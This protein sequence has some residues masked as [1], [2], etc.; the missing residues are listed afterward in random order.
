VVLSV[1]ERNALL[2][3]AWELRTA[4]DYRGLDELLTPIPL[5]TL[6]SEPEL[7]YWLASAW[8][9]LGRWSNSL[10]LLRAMAEPCRRRGND[11]IF[12]DRMN[13]EA[14][15][16]IR[17]G[18]LS[19]AESLLLDL[20]QAAREA[21]DENSSMLASANVGIIYNIQGRWED[22]FASYQFAIVLC[23]RMGNRRFLGLTHHNLGI[24]C[25]QLTLLHE[26]HDHFRKARDHLR[27]EG[28]ADQIA[29]SGMERAILL[30][31]MGDVQLAE[32]TVRRAL[33]E[34]IALGHLPGEGDCRRVLGIISSGQG[35]HE[36][37]RCYFQEALEM[38]RAAGEPLTEAEVLEEMAVLDQQVGNG[39]VASA[40]AEAAYAIYLRLGS[41]PR[42]EQLRV[43]LAALT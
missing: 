27:A 28:S 21:V 4:L 20:N 5:A 2:E 13:L 15:V 26:A 31:L 37:A 23:Q 11:R 3:R 10:A 30:N 41:P 40:L 35:R 19:E 25:R 6:L 7:G 8:E 29:F 14:I 38:V 22:A 9:H 17:L 42:A 43:R 32:A 1:E 34:F 16:L 33:Q 18:A 12:R 39:A 36:E 24:A